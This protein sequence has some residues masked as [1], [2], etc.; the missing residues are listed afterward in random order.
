MLYFFE[1]YTKSDS[2]ELGWT[3]E[4][5]TVRNARDR[6]SA[7]AK[8]CRRWGQKFDCVI[9]LYQVASYNNSEG[10]SLDASV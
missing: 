3:I 6:Q 10:W 8:L 4:T 9:Q 5:G 7:K 1:I 2:G